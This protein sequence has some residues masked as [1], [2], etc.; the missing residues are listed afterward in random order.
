MLS[1]LFCSHATSRCSGRI[2]CSTYGHTAFL[3]LG[4]MSLITWTTAEVLSLTSWLHLTLL[5]LSFPTG[6]R[7]IFPQYK[8]DHVSPPSKTPVDSHLNWSRSRSS[9]V[10]NYLSELI[11]CHLLIVPSWRTTHR[12]VACNLFPSS[13]MWAALSR[14]SLALEHLHKASVVKAWSSAQHSWAMGAAL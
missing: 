9:S 14:V 8:S 10:P 11:S 13:L 5:E 1:V 2:A 6:A 4:A 12:T 7:V 3:L